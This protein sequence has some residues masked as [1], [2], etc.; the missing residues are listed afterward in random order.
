MRH[1][2]KGRKLGR[3]S[4]HRKAMLRNLV[5]NLFVVAPKED[6]PRRVTT[7]VPKAK[8]ARRLAERAITLGKRGTLHARRR[9]LALL[10][11]KRVVKLVFEKIAPLYNGRVGGY[12]RILRLP[13]WRMGDGT[14][15]CYFELVAGAV[16]PTAAEP[17]APR[18]A[19]EEQATGAT[20]EQSAGGQA[21]AEHQASEAQDGEPGADRA[22]AEGG[23]QPQAGGERQGEP[24]QSDKEPPS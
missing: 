24:P 16:E 15:L 13:K 18:G 11:N 17:V 22:A 8:E 2:K 10:Q 19:T 9:A 4:A 20:L 23:Q 14:D 6:H 3:T 5:C 7:T 12:T 21:P 1:R